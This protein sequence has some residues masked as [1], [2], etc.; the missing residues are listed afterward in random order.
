M[1]KT[2]NEKLTEARPGPSKS[3]EPVGGTK[4]S[5]IITTAAPKSTVTPLM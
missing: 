1:N 3:Q 4:P 2:Q 5:M